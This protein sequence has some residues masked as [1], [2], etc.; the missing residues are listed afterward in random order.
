MASITSL[1]IGLY[2]GSMI[3]APA[4]QF[5]A[6]CLDKA[7]VTLSDEGPNTF[8]V[9][10]RADRAPGLTQDYALLSS[11]L[12]KAT[13]RLALTVSVNG[14]SRVLMDGFITRQEMKH[15]GP[16]GGATLT[17]TGQDVSVLM[18]LFQISF[19][20]PSLPDVAIVGVVLA[21]YSMIGIIPEIIPTPSS[22]VPL[23]ID[24]TPQHNSTDRDYL[25]QLASPHG[26]VFYVK[27]GPVLGTN[28]A[29]WGPPMRLG[30]PQPA[31]TV[32]MGPGSNVESLSF[33]YDAMAPSLVHG[34]VQDNID[35]I[36]AP[37]ITLLSTRIPP[38][39]SS[40]ALFANQPFV[41]NLQ[42]TD[43]RV[44]ILRSYD[45]AQSITDVSTDKVVTANGSLDTYRY[46]AILD[47]P[48]LI[49]V[50]GAGNNYDGM[51]YIQSVTHSISRAEYKQEFV[52]NREGTGSLTQVVT[53]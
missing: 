17:V 44:G 8:Q 10:F 46:G 39:A 28:I 49:G 52:L 6:E 36:G 37:V 26:Y 11:S 38:F 13:S 43:P 51:Y 34:M 5:I 35:E 47:A 42:F 29:Y 25:K 7:E 40:P 3:P 41:R 33:Q 20:Y 15:E 14:T 22:L 19:E 1:Q 32:D 45:L 53:P 16:A 2:L 48:G 4:P 23:P 24:W 9:S 50:R 27:P 31:L 30:I 21:K 18:D 12:L